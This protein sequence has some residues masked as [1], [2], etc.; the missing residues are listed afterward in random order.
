[1]VEYTIEEAV[2]AVA[3]EEIEGAAI[4]EADSIVV[5]GMDVLLIQLGFI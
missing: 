2:D 3:I 5:I 4:I 1:M